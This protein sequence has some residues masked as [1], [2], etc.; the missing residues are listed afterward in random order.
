MANIIFISGGVRSGK[1]SYAEKRAIRMAECEH[2]NLYYIAC[3]E[4]VDEEM[5][6]RIAQHK[7]D[8]T[9]SM[10]LWE[11]IESPVNV[12]SVAPRIDSGG[13]VLLDCL[14]TLL[15]NELFKGGDW[16]DADFQKRMTKKITSDLNAIAENCDALIIVSNELSFEPFDSDLVKAYVRLLGY[17]HQ[18]VVER[19]DEACLVEASI[20][21]LMKG[22]VVG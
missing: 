6:A 15:S 5:K 22:E 14:T 10:F 8:R 19:A 3:G 20:P 21:I 4:P 7:Y 2:K 12:G 17:L 11:T 13:I 16:S 9:T 1:S 18:W